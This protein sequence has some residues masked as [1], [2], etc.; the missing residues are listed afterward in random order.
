MRFNES[1]CP[2]CDFI[3][4]D[5]EANARGYRTCGHDAVKYRRK[6]GKRFDIIEDGRIKKESRKIVR[7]CEEHA[8]E[9]R[10]AGCDIVEAENEYAYE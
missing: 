7:L 2:R 6:N 8:D 1:V 10:R 5:K 9:Y 3:I 4:Y